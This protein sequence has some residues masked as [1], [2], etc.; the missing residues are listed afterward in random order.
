MSPTYLCTYV[1]KI[2]ICN[3]NARLIFNKHFFMLKE[4]IFWWMTAL[5][6]FDMYPFYGLVVIKIDI[7]QYL[8]LWNY[9]DQ[10]YQ[11][12]ILC[13]VSDVNDRFTSYES[14]SLWN[15]CRFAFKAQKKASS[16]LLNRTNQTLPGLSYLVFCVDVQRKPMKTTDWHFAEEKKRIHNHNAQSLLS[17]GRR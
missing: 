7:N 11:C 16:W 17:S 3:M 14:S 8:V 12:N 1:F 5:G 4:W 9:F 15:A 10:E 2:H 13:D 6:W